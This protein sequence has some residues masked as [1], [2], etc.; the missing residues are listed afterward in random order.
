MSFILKATERPIDQYSHQGKSAI[1]FALF[2]SLSHNTATVCLRLA[3]SSERP[4]PEH[5]TAVDTVRDTGDE[6]V[7]RGIKP[8]Q[9]CTIWCYRNQ[10]TRSFDLDRE[11]ACS[12][13][14]NISSVYPEICQ[15]YG[16]LSVHEPNLGLG[17]RPL[18]A[19]W[20]SLLMSLSVITTT[21]VFIRSRNKANMMRGKVKE[22]TKEWG[23]GRVVRTRDGLV[24]K[25]L[26]T[27]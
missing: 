18:C 15:S 20:E 23:E 21:A 12:F 4:S 1:S 25:G 27:D 19:C 13:I 14:R 6:C 9:G 10:T 24:W 8:G 26:Q 2:F 16:L 22:K 17:S 7:E 11:T 5:V 3:L